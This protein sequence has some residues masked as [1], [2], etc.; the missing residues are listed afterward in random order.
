MQSLTGKNAIVTGASRGIGRA[1]AERLA[2]DGASVA[3]NFVRGRAA[4]EDVV[5]SIEQAGGKAVAVQGDVGAHADIVRLFDA[6]EQQFGA[7]D[8]VVASAGVSVFKPHAQVSPEE[9]EQ[10]FSVNTRGVFFILQ[11]AARRVRDGGR[12]LQ[13]SSAATAM[14]YPAA[15]LY[16]GSK[17]AAER[18]V[19]ALAK[20]LGPRGITVNSISPGM[21]E[22]DGLIMPEEA[23]AAL[24][25][26]TPLGRLG[27]PADIAEVAAFLVSEQGRWMT[28]QN[29]RATGGV[30]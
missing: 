29:L 24:V 30:V 28:G 13:I 15:G 9:Y 2:A 16:A 23:I 14:A 8:I 26:Q 21:T 18:F 19:A 27:Q 11:E 7:L 5:R 10:V 4:A 6:T 20:E 3:V 25:Q 22:T 1:I 17:A 12:V